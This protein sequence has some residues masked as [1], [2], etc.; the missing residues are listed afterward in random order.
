[1]PAAASSVAGF[2]AGGDA[3]L[4]NVAELLGR[5]V[6][7]CT[8]EVCVFDNRGVGGSSV[9]QDKA[10]Y[11]TRRMAADALALMVSQYV[12][13]AP[14]AAGRAEPSEEAVPCLTMCCGCHCQC[15]GSMT[16]LQPGRM[17]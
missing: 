10:R 17:A 4:P 2:A 9:P 6:L 14:P 5:A 3:W 13:V 12:H 1:M 8:L 11:S 7:P 15:Q 16:W